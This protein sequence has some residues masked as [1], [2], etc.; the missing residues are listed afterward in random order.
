MSRKRIKYFVDGSGLFTHGAVIFMALAA[1]FTLFGSLGQRS[2]RYFML[3]GLALPLVCELLFL[4]MLALFGS[5]TM[6]LTALPAVM[7]S[8][9]FIIRAFSF[10]NIVYMVIFM[11][12][13]LTAAILY[14]ATVFGWVRNKWLLSAFIFICFAL[15]VVLRDYPALSGGTVSVTFPVLMQEISILFILLALLFAALALKNKRSLEEAGL[16]KMRSP[17]VIIKNVKEDVKNS[18]EGKTTSSPAVMPPE[19]PTGEIAENKESSAI[20]LSGSTEITDGEI[21]SS[22]NTDK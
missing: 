7:F 8:V 19:S 16:P 18:L 10:D 4:A 3:T 20:P 11:T 2:D 14:T 17:K 5:R 6:S 22:E 1:I 9:F 12:V 13:Y 15:N 21:I